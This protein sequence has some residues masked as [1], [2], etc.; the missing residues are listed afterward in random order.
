M[1][2]IHTA[3]THLHMTRTHT[4]HTCITTRAPG[5]DKRLAHKCAPGVNTFFIL[6]SLCNRDC[7]GTCASSHTT[8]LHTERKARH[9]CRHSPTHVH[10][11]AHTLI[12]SIPT[13]PWTHSTHPGDTEH[14]KNPHEEGILLHA[15]WAMNVPVE[16]QHN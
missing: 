12:Q 1:L 9:T 13:S 5:I 15:G 8:H 14:S 16:S 2:L 11:A 3:H 7:G 6:F 4:T 10:R